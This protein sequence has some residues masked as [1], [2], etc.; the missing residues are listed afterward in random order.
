LLTIP[1]AGFEVVSD[2]AGTAWKVSDITGATA[3]SSVLMM[4]SFALAAWL[5]VDRLRA[6]EGGARGL[7][8]QGIAT[9]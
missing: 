1:R 8:T 3:L 7:S 5:R 9:E 6:K 2:A 4:G